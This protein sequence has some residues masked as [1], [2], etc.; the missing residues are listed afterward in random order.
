MRKTRQQRQPERRQVK[1][2]MSK[3]MAAHV[4]YNS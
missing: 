4:C 1:G 2:L 3:T